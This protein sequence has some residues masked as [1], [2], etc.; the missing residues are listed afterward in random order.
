MLTSN[1]ITIANKKRFLMQKDST[2]YARHRYLQ[3][4]R[5]NPEYKNKGAAVCF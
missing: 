4:D 1:P 5:H 2:F 3:S